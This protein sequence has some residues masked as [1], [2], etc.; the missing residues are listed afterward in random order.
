MRHIG[1]AGPWRH[2][3]CSVCSH[4]CQMV[5][6]S[7]RKILY[8]Q[9]FCIYAKSPNVQKARKQATQKW[10]LASQYVLEWCVVV[11]KISLRQRLT[12]I[13]RLEHGALQEPDVGQANIIS[14]LNWSNSAC[15]CHA[16]FWRLCLL[17]VAPTMFKIGL[18]SCPS[19]GLHT[20]NI[21]KFSIWPSQRTNEHN[22]LDPFNLRV[23]VE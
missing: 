16:C 14:H 19:I 17:R 5:G 22:R 20:E 1:I 12:D 9:Q 4:A 11:G 18:T 7:S 13:G 8:S 6:T 23:Q 2:L 15:C 3:S 21:A 10:F